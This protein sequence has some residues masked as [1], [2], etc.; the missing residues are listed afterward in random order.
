MLNIEHY[1]YVHFLKNV[2]RT[3]LR[4]II[5]KAL[6]VKY[7]KYNTV[8]HL[9]VYMYMYIGCICIICVV[10]IRKRGHSLE[11]YAVIPIIVCALY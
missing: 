3:A 9:Y 4:S 7:G 2:N 6:Y 1:Y 5:V 8:Q 10:D 11:R